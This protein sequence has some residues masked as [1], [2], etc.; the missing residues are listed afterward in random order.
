MSTTEEIKTRLDIVQYVQQYVPLKKAGRYHKACCPFHSERT[1]SFVVNADTQSWRCFGACAEGGDLFS[2]A[3]KYHN[4]T[5]REALEELARQAGVEL[6]RATPEQEQRNTYLDRLRGLLSVAAEAYHKYLLDASRPDAAAALDYLHS[7]R[8]LT[9]ET[10]AQFG[11]GYA[12]DGWQNLLNHLLEL[13][14]TEDEIIEAGLALRSEKGR[15]YDR[16][17]NRVIIPIRDERGR[18]VGF[19]G[20]VL[21]PEDSPKYLNSPQSPV[22]DKSRLLFGLDVARQA[23]SHTETAVIVE[24][25]MDVIQAHQA[26]FANVVAQ[27]GTALTEAQLHLLVPR[28]TRRVVLALDA[29]AAGQ[30]ATMRSLEVARQTLQSDYAGRLAADIRILQ[31]PGAKDPDDLLRETP[32]EWQALVENARPVAD[33]VIDVEVSALP[34]QPTIQEKQ[35]VARRLLPLLTASEDNLLRRDNLQK[36]AQRLRIAE[37]DLMVWVEELRRQEAARPSRPAPAPAPEP[38]PEP[39]AAAPV[40]VGGSYRQQEA[41]CLR[42]LIENPEQLYRVNR[43]LRELC[44]DHRDNRDLHRALQEGPLCEFGQQDFSSGDYRLLMAALLEALRQD[45]LEPL[46]YLRESS[47]PELY[48]ELERLQIDDAGYISNHLNGRQSA[49]TTLA[50]KQHEQQSKPLVDWG[51]EMMLGVLHLRL[52]RLK[53]EQ[54]DLQFLQQDEQST[55]QIRALWPYIRASHTAIH[56]IDRELARL[57]T[58]RNKT[59]IFAE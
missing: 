48:A 29:D 39:A 44:D 28:Y 32:D 35:A 41:Y 16:F 18:V 9:D 34:E 47:S 4:W 33:Y 6:E 53:R 36:L 58:M 15:V 24:G 19:G 52:Y 26:G 42:L 51:V 8:G 57:Q 37:N 1:P 22:F 46:D 49:D 5:F 43:R 14:Y 13:G 17:R 59:G 56:T 23:I 11:V 25:Y 20:R 31:M 27:M 55:E 12:P 54:Q 2:F 21:D 50:L 40:L 38:P 45:K 7:R 30:N 10:I 3:M